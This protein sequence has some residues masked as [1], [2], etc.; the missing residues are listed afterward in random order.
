MSTSF[1]KSRGTVMPNWEWVRN[2]VTTTDGKWVELASAPELFQNAESV[3]E[4]ANMLSEVL[5][6]GRMELEVDRLKFLSGRDLLEIVEALRM[7]LDAD[8]VEQ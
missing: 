3:Q 8:E 5:A 4:Q 6:G 1:W 7:T 2:I